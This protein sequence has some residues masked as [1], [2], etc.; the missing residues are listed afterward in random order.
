[1]RIMLAKSKI[2]SLNIDKIVEN[3]HDDPTPT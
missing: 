2:I 3:W 1:M